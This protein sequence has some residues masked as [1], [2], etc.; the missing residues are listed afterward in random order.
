MIALDTTAIVDFFKGDPKIM[1]LL[2][3]LDEP[4]SSTIINYQEIM[5]GLDLENPHHLEEEKYYDLFFNSI[6]TFHLDEES[7]KKATKIDWKL[8]KKGISSGR[9]DSIIAGIITKNGVNKI[10]TRNVKHFDKIEGL[11]VISY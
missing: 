3:N 4:L 6:F 5:F 9:F 7:S 2:E 10:I 11:K 1:K 8:K